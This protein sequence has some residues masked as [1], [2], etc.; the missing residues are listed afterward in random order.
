L[1]IACV[2]ILLLT[3]TSPLE[4]TLGVN[5]RSVYLH[6]AWVWA[7]LAAFAAAAVMGL[8]G[9]L[10]RRV[11]LH[12]WSRALGRTSLLL[13]ISFLPMSLYIMQANWNGLF[14]AE[15]RWRIPFSFAIVCALLQAGLSF[16]PVSWASIANLIFAAALFASMQGM[17]NVLHPI[18]PVMSSDS[19]PI[20]LFFSGLFVLIV[21][22]ACQVTRIFYR[23]EAR[24]LLEQRRD[25]GYSPQGKN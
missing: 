5:A 12:G 13:W 1:V 16:F 23:L 20:Q 3:I 24:L 6:G 14:F 7:A 4:K 15:P 11:S 17:D 9:I 19:L 2:L 25:S 21:L 18:S 22:A 10:S 8:A